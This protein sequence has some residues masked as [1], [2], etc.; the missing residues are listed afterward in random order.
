MDMSLTGIKKNSALEAA[1]NYSRSVDRGWFYNDAAFREAESEL[2]SRFGKALAEVRRRLTAA[3]VTDR[4]AVLRA[5]MP[6]RL[7]FATQ[8]RTLYS[9][10]AEIEQ[11]RRRIRREQR[12]SLAHGLLS[13]IV[14][15]GTRGLVSAALNRQ[16][17]S[18]SRNLN[19]QRYDLKYGA[20]PAYD[21]SP[22]PQ[23]YDTSPYEGTGR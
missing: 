1:G 14:N 7:H 23:A 22:Y 15:I 10:Q 6:V 19:R 2:R 9:R 3:G 21:Y 4:N 17:Y 20:Q 11:E 13:T 16:R 18:H 12:R 5:E 8:F